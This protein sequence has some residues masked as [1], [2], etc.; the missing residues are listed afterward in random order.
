MLDTNFHQFPEI[1]KTE[2]A[3]AI[4]LKSQ[5]EQ[6]LQNIESVLSKGSFHINFS[7][8]HKNF[9]TQSTLKAV[10]KALKVVNDLSEG[11][12]KTIPPLPIEPEVNFESQ[13]EEV[14]Q[15][16]NTDQGNRGNKELERSQE[17]E[18]PASGDRTSPKSSQDLKGGEESLKK[19]DS[20]GE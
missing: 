10:N 19:V 4:R 14:A 5:T 3:Q 7:N 1:K 15:Q 18:K 6:S 17:E 9:Q 8:M 2:S 16:S 13:T 12:V 11:N 20:N